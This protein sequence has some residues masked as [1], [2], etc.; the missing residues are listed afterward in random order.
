MLRITEGDR[1]AI[2]DPAE[3]VAQLRELGLE[4]KGER[5]DRGYLHPHVLMSARRAA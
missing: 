3:Y 2:A 1:V 5:I 4:V